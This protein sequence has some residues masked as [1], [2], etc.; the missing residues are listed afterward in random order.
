MTKKLV[1]ALLGVMLVVPTTSFAQS[2]TDLQSQINAILQQIAALQKMVI[3]QQGSSSG[4]SGQT[5]VPAPVQAQTQV[6]YGQVVSACRELRNTLRAGTKG[7]DV[8]YLQTLLQKEGFAISQDEISGQEYGESTA[9]AVTGLQEKYRSEI[10]AP[11]GLKYGSGLVGAGTRKK[12]NALYGCLQPVIQPPQPPIEVGAP[13]IHS[14]S[15]PTVLKSGEVGT[16]TIKASDPNNGTLRY[17]VIWGD[18][19]SG[20][21][22]MMTTPLENFVQTTTFTHTYYNPGSVYEPVFYVT[23]DS[24]RITKKS[25][26]VKIIDLSGQAPVVSGVSGPTTLKVGEVGTWKVGVNA[27]YNDYLSYSVIWGD[28]LAQ[29]SSDGSS[30]ARSISQSAT[31]THAYQQ[32][33]TYY[34]IFYV[35]NQ[36]GQSAKTS[37]SVQ[38]GGT[39]T[40]TKPDIII[41]DV[42]CDPA[43]P[44]AHE[45][46]TCSVTVANNSSVDITKSFDVNI[47]GIAVTISAPLNAWEKKTVKAPSPFGLTI[48]GNNTLNFPADIWNSVDESNEDNNVFTTTIN[49]GDAVVVSEQVKCVFDGATSEQK[50]YTA[51]NSSDKYYNLGCSGVGACVVDLKGNKGDQ[52]T[53]KSSCGGYAYT[54]MDG[55]NEYAKF[56]CGTTQPSGSISIYPATISLGV[57]ENVKIKAYYSPVCP[58]GAV[59]T[60]AIREIEPKW[61]VD[62][63][64]VATL[65]STSCQSQPGSTCDAIIPTT[66]INGMAA[67][68]TTLRATW[69]GD[70]GA[71]A[72]TAT[73]PVTVN[74]SPPPIPTV[75]EQVKCLF[76]GTTSEQKCYTATNSSDKYYNLG[77][78]GVG[79]CVADVKGNKGDQITW[80][81]SCGGYAYTT[82]DGQNEYAKFSCSGTVPPPIP[83]PIPTVSEQVKCLFD[84]DSTSKQSCYIASPAGSNYAAMGCD[85]IG[86]CVVDL[87]GNKGDQVTWKSSCGGYAYTT[88]DGQNEYAKFSCGTTQLTLSVSRNSFSP[89]GNIYPGANGAELF[90]IDISAK[91]QSATIKQLNLELA[92]ILDMKGVSNIKAYVDGV[93]VGTLSDLTNTFSHYYT[94]NINTSGLTIPAGST[95]VVSIRGDVSPDIWSDLSS[96]CPSCTKS[97]WLVLK[98]IVTDPAINQSAITGLPVNGNSV[99]IPYQSPT[100]TSPQTGITSQSQAAATLETM[101]AMLEAMLLKIM[102]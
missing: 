27:N 94:G 20:I 73:A 70:S 33:G 63:T 83:T 64:S 37:I 52:I 13:I 71:V 8:S 72:L 95:K 102:Q 34:P 1:I 14:V 79:A 77:C 50:C 3:N 89:G 35:T 93:T 49:V 58:P 7:E 57:G 22:G 31:M 56:S 11:V 91:G 17:R 55:Q 5:T 98:N 99:Y 48:L 23:N 6:N 2:A 25:L 62:N 45:W 88:M 21:S 32:A 10:L 24:G 54:T 90:R 53:W 84:G 74:V 69:Q 78:S 28:E 9:S 65:I 40:S 92:G 76:D 44:K 36:N 30:A 46:I 82:M 75:S 97:L 66:Q 38:V 100:T 19:A 41:S 18:E 87:K 43:N 101:R 67:G 68:K 15:G 39:V 4:Q 51:T 47:Q 42:V 86:A 60:M 59:C 85:G 81:S 61:T 16:W 12:L 26:T 29:T 80:K 96:P